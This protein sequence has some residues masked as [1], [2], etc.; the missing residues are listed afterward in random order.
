MIVVLFLLKVHISLP[1]YKH[2]DHVHRPVQ[3][4]EG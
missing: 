1:Q 4:Q 2:Q 3:H